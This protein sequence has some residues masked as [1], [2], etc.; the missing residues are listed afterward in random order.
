MAKVDVALAAPHEQG[1]AG[2]PPV[3]AQQQ[4]DEGVI[5]PERVE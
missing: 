2:Q 1:E 4:R 3:D 5:A